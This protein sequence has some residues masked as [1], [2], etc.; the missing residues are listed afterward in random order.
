MHALMT[1]LTIVLMYALYYLIPATLLLSLLQVYLCRRPIVS[2]V[3]G[4][5]A[6]LVVG[7]VVGTNLIG[8]A[9]VATALLALAALVLFNIPT[10]VYVLIYRYQKRRRE[11]ED[12]DRMK[13]DDLE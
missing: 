12:L 4:V 13:I 8:T 7:L 11:R 1:L 5:A 10:L 2:A 6:A 9:Y 3:L